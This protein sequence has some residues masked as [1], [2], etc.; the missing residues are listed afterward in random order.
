MILIGPRFKMQWFM[1]QLLHAMEHNEP[2]SADKIADP[3]VLATL[4]VQMLREKFQ[5]PRPGDIGAC[6]VVARSLVAMEAVFCVG[7]GEDLDLRLLSLDCLD[8]G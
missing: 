8:V 6:L 5:A 1:L 4:D 3:L 7:I 2:R